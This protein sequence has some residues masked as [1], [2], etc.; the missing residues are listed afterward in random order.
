MNKGGLVFALIA[1]ISLGFLIGYVIQENKI[2]VAVK[3]LNDCTNN[4]NMWQKVSQDYL[5]LLKSGVESCM[6]E[7]SNGISCDDF[8]GEKGKF[9]F[10]LR[11]IGSKDLS[12]VTLKLEGCGETDTTSL[13]AG[14]VGT[15]E[16]PCTTL[17]PYIYKELSIYYDG[18]I[19]KGYVYTTIK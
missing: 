13:K 16:I 15:F 14:E 11:N 10:K 8:S 2:S 4:A 19:S 18:K 3:S 1:T 6:V 7:A 9:T 17:K 12:G 5:N